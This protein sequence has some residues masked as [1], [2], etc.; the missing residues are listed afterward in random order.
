[1]ECEDKL[2]ID[3]PRIDFGSL[4]QYVVGWCFRGDGRSFPEDRIYANSFANQPCLAR[5]HNV[6]VQ[7]WLDSSPYLVQWAHAAWPP[8][9]G[10]FFAAL[11]AGLLLGGAWFARE[12]TRTARSQF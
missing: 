3:W 11:A 5:Y 6:C 12:T 1:M 2:P 7:A 8:T 4:A 10:N 9:S